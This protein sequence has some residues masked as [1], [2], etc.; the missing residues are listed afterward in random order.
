[1]DEETTFET[2]RANA[3]NWLCKT[4]LWAGV[5]Y[6]KAMYLYDLAWRDCEILNRDVRGREVARQL[7]RSVGGISANLEEAFGR[8]VRSADARR[9]T[10]IALGEAREARGWYARSRHLLPEKV[11]EHRIALLD[12][13]IRLLVMLIR[14]PVS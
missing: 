12:E 4:P 11:V 2:W 7:I 14:R 13:I 10:R 3:P 5:H 6:Q 9:I 8:G 1:M